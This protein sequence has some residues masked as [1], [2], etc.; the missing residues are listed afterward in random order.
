MT[1]I[2]LLF[3]LGIVLIAIE[4]II[5]GGILGVIGALMIFGGCVMS[6]IEFGTWG[7]IAASAIAFGLG[8]LTLFIEFRIL[9]RPNSAS[10]PSS[11]RRSPA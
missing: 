9:P 10:A 2:I 5:P 3:A 6:F 4:V 7:G 8:A 11:A 1:L